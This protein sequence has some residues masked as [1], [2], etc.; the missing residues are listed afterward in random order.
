M[1][2]FYYGLPAWLSTLLV[3]GI[4]VAIGIGSSVGVQALF[5]LKPT[6]EEKEIAINL[7]QVVAAYIGI[8]LA[9]SGVVVWQNFA[10][11]EVSV[12]QEA[13]TAAELYR[14][15]TTYG[16]ETLAA[17]EDLRSYV[18]SIISDEW[19]RLREGK[20]STSTEIALGRL[21]EEIGKINPQDN[22]DGVIYEESFSKL[23]DLVVIRRNRI[24]ASQT[25]I[26]IIFWLVGLI[27]SS[28]TIGYASAFSRSRYNFVM[29]SGTSITLG[30]VFL[31][32]LTVDK[33]FKGQLRVP[34]SDFLEL[35]AT[36][37]RLDRL[38]LKD[39]DT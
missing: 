21:F 38:I 14:D 8:M 18:G 3:L 16:S 25:S 2:D 33:P 24:I 20:S 5:R 27:G 28:L 11:A 10:D 35:S 29:I 39:H 4:S 17:R 7:M 32:I 30:L 34:S 19:P 12:H 26:P 15:L 9:F 13:A 6:D 36:F 37:D 23:N 1:A 31:F 22:R